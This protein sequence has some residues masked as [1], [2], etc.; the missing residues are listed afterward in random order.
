MTLSKAKKAENAAKRAATIKA[1]Q[2][3]P[4]PFTPAPFQSVEDDDLPVAAPL[5]APADVAA[6]VAALKIASAP[7]KPAPQTGIRGSMRGDIRSAPQG[8]IRQR[9]GHI[10]PF[11]LPK[12]IIGAFTS[13]GWS[14]EWKRDTVFGEK[15]VSYASALLEN[16]WESVNADEIPGVMPKGHN[17]AITRDGL[18]LMKR[19]SYLTQDA[20]DE[21]LDAAVGQVRRKEAQARET[22][23]GTLTRDHQTVPHR[24]V[25]ETGPM[26][27][28]ND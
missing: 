12:E 20:R 17:G 5:I 26:P 15:D 4:Q 8:L 7:T 14:L 28:P 16:H 9:R 10:D 18:M 23:A 24:I 25:K 3:A 1:D 13:A 21:E 27:V 22:P 19:P 11:E 6:T 2:K